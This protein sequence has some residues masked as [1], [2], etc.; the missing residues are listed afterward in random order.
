MAP[1][2]R[3]PINIRTTK[4]GCSSCAWNGR[5]MVSICAAFRDG[6]SKAR[7]RTADAVATRID[8]GS[9]AGRDLRFPVPALPGGSS[10][11]PSDRGT[12]LLDSADDRQSSGRRGAGAIL[13]SG[14]PAPPGE[15]RRNQRASR[16]RA[17]PLAA[18]RGDRPGGAG[19]VYADPVAGVRRGVSGADHQRPPFVSAGLHRRPAVSR[20]I[21]TGE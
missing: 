11:P 8:V 13:R 20:G 16:R 6:V 15:A 3:M 1:T 14:V 19:A 2:S 7:G 12:A 21:S 10:S 5:W 4:P 9:P 18:R 17:A